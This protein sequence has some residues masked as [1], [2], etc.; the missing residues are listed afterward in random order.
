MYNT[1]AFDY[2]KRLATANGAKVFTL[3]NLLGLLGA[4]P[5]VNTHLTIHAAKTLG[6]LT[7]ALRSRLRY[8]QDPSLFTSKQGMNTLTVANKTN[9]FFIYIELY[10]CIVNYFG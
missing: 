4:V 9:S 2:K 1:C 5:D 3:Q 10:I 6:D 7:S 8:Y